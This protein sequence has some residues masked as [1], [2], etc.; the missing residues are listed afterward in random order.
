M[1]RR[2]VV[3]AILFCFSFNAAHATEASGCECASKAA[4]L[5]AD[6]LLACHAKPVCEPHIMDIETALRVQAR[7]LSEAVQSYLELTNNPILTDQQREFFF[8]ATENDKHRIISIKNQLKIKGYEDVLEPLYVDFDSSDKNYH[9]YYYSFNLGYEYVSLNDIFQKGVPRIGF[10]LYRR[11]GD[12]PVLREGMGFYG[13]HIF[14]SLQL[15]SSAEQGL[16]IEDDGVRKTLEA[17]VEQYFPV[18]HSLLRLDARLSDYLG[19][20]VSYGAKKN[21]AEDSI[22]SRL[23]VGIRNAMNA[24]TYIDLM[25]GRSEGLASTRVE[26][27]AHIPVY[28][29]AF[30]SR[31]F[32]GGVINMGFPGLDNKGESD[33]I[34]FFMEWNA[35]FGKI[36]QGISSAVGI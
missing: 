3:V 18:F 9:R 1:L 6:V 24:E 8:A 11:Y 23:Y 21:D 15:T 34:R 35:D 14:G 27:R 7:H 16:Q 32:L 13:Y 2:L 29:F 31:I 20:I 17:S 25:V 26:A 33:V 5:P 4:L 22:R 10:L 30:G 28:K 36:V 12:V 19:P